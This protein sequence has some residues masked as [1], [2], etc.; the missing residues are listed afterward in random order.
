VH[1][2]CGRGK[3][4][5]MLR[6]VRTRHPCNDSRH[7]LLDDTDRQVH[8]VGGEVCYLWMPYAMLQTTEVYSSRGHVGLRREAPQKWETPERRPPTC[9][10]TT[11]ALNKS[12]YAVKISVYPHCSVSGPGFIISSIYGYKRIR[13]QCSRK[14]VQQLKKRK[15]SCFCWFWKNVKKRTYSFT[16][17]LIT[18]RLIH[19]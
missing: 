16:C 9:R 8:V 6:L 19:N 3:M 13:N 2:D 12:R 15:K 1:V 4:G 18:L 14:R 10:S 5:S 17:H 7:I 11:Y